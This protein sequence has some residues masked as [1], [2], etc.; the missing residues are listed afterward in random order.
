MVLGSN[1]KVGESSTYGD[2]LP[3]PSHIPAGT[4]AHL[5]VFGFASSSVD[6]S[7]QVRE[8]KPEKTPIIPFEVTFKGQYH[9]LQNYYPYYILIQH[10]D[11]AS[12][13]RIDLPLPPVGITYSTHTFDY[14]EA[15]SPTDNTPVTYQGVKIVFS[16]TFILPPEQ[17][18]ISYRDGLDDVV[19]THYVEEVTG[20]VTKFV[21]DQD[22]ILAPIS[23]QV[24]D[25]N[26]PP[27]IFTA[28]FTVATRPVYGIP[29]D[30]F[31]IPPN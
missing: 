29:W 4:S 25:G 13:T 22:I 30:G 1:V 28:D 23:F 11:L 3:R 8:S 7:D 2:D 24:K 16:G 5:P 15:T 27:T 12:V 26:S 31:P 9:Y 18:H 19:T 6:F 20:A 17:V 10:Y 14:L 21:K